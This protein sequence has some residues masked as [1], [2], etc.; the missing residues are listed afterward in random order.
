MT[1]GADLEPTAREPVARP[2]FRRWVVA[3]CAVPA[4]L[5]IAF[6][7]L[8][9]TGG[10]EGKAP[11]DVPAERLDREGR[12]AGWREALEADRW[13]VV[14]AA[15]RGLDGLRRGGATYA[16][17][18]TPDGGGALIVRPDGAPGMRIERGAHVLVLDDGR[19]VARRHERM[20]YVERASLTLALYDPATLPPLADVA[21]PKP[22]AIAG[23]DGAWRAEAPPVAAFTFPLGAA[24]GVHAVDVPAAFREIGEIVTIVGAYAE[25]I[26][27]R[28]PLREPQAAFVLDPV[29]GRASILPF[30]WFNRPRALPHG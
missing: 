17:R 13:R 12:F 20:P 7:A 28:T 26:T 14:G 24:P 15:V 9:R 30:A 6:L 2:A 11:Y 5:L 22:G 16:V 18:S 23:I 8:A 29:A 19:F 27:P 21:P 3:A 25:S 1:P 10:K 4:L